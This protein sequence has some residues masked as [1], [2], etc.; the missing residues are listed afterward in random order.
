M[1]LFLLFALLLSGIY[2]LRRDRGDRDL[3][4]IKLTPQRGTLLDEVYGRGHV[5]S[6]VNVDITSPLDGDS[7]IVQILP[8]GVHVEKDE[9]IARL[10]TEKLENRINMYQYWL[11]E[12][13]GEVEQHKNDLEKYE[14]DL[15]DYLMGTVKT[16]CMEIENDIVKKKEALRQSLINVKMSDQLLALGYTTKAQVDIDQV[17]CQKNE[18]DLKE[19]LLEKEIFLKYTSEKEITD[20]ISN[21]EA[22]KT[23]MDESADW[24]GTI[25]KSLKKLLEQYDSAVIKAPNP[26]R[27]VYANQVLRPGRNENEMIREGATVKKGQLLF[28]IPDPSSM[29]IQALLTEENVFRTKPGMKASFVFDV[30]KNY[31]F[32]GEV[33]K[34]NQYPELD[35]HSPVKKYIVQIKI[36]DTARI[37]KAGI[38]LRTG[39]SADVRIVVNEEKD[40]LMIP[41]HAVVSSGDKD[42]CLFFNRGKW[43]YREILLGTISDRMAVVLEG[44]SEKD[45]IVAGAVKYKEK[46]SLPAPGDPS[47]FKEKKE[48]LKK[49]RAEKELLEKDRAKNHEN[50]KPEPEKVH[51]GAPVKN[52]NEPNVQKNNKAQ[53]EIKI[54]KEQYKKYAPLRKY[55]HLTTVEFCR[56][57]DRNS[58]NKIGTDEI[59]KEMPELFPLIKDWDRNQNGTLEY[60]DLAIGLYK[61]RNI[62]KKADS[63]SLSQNENHEIK[64]GDNE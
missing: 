9:P 31:S 10:D 53:D 63:L 60:T 46:I 28:R 45:V 51:P 25:E 49:E 11:D 17:A 13:P 19:S 59:K 4:I 32:D 24:T 47:R 29:Q 5:S 38:D 12:N 8:E 57:L 26:G 1:S 48:I 62:C 42:F 21:M 64:G 2:Y 15:E 58:D 50:Q 16:K 30:Q 41:V 54:I 20:I 55:F 3:N 36:N 34:V 33:I 43:D 18:N 61:A 40:R 52:P 14:F 7:T 37:L 27:I 6:A 39:F 35:R 56:K 23:A 22:T 44:L